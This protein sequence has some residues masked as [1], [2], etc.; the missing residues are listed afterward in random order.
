MLAVGDGAKQAVLDRISGMGTNLLLVRPGH[1]QPRRR[2]SGTATMTPE[3]ADAIAA[4]PNVLA[5]VPELGGTV[6]ARFG[7]LD[8]QTQATATRRAT[9]RWRATGRWRAAR[10]SST[11]DV[12]SYAPVVV[13]G[14]T[15]VDN[16]LPARRAIRSASTI[17]LNNVPVPGHRRHA[18]QRGASP[19]GRTRTTPVFV[20][21]HH[22]QPAALRPALPAQHHRARSTT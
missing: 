4:L 3:D 12:R 11:A 19:T 1:V 21:L 14:Q 15:V 7:N 9:S 10:S 6:T 2:G 18:P 8:Y 20:P 5:A 17:V 16:A 13:L 22:R